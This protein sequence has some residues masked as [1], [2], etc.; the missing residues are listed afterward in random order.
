MKFVV[1]A[2]V[3]TLVVA[4]PRPDKD[5]ETLVDERTDDGKGQFYVH[6]ATSN[7]ITETREGTPGEKGQS[8]IAGSYSFILL[9]GTNAEFTY[10]ADEEGIRVESPLLPTSPP[11]PAHSLAQIDFARQEDKTS[12]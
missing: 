12:K 2:C 10:V 7:D 3:V 4:A 11:I 1:L 8:N 6:Y 9:D 5:A